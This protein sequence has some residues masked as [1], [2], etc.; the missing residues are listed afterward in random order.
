MSGVV[1]HGQT[2]GLP[3]RQ[4]RCLAD[5]NGAERTA[6]WGYRAIEAR[7]ISKSFRSGK[8]SVEALHDI[9]IAVGRGEVVS[10][11]GPSGSG[12]STLLHVLAGL[13]SPERG[14]VVID[15][16]RVENPIGRTALMPQRDL[17]MPWKTVLENVTVGMR[18]RGV[19]RHDAREEALRLFPRFGLEGFESA[20]PKALSGGMRQR[21]AL[22]RTL[23]TGR[24]IL[25]L[26]EPLGALDAITRMEMQAWLLEVQAS[27]QTTMLLVTHDVDEALYLSDR[28]AVLSGRPGRVVTT[29]AVPFSRPRSYE[30]TVTSSGFA[31][32]KR[33][34]LHQLREGLDE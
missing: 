4:R 7:H 34:I 11:L 6:D 13:I 10:I 9:S 24:D 22:L 21:A 18:L 15:G 29:H 1:K 26:D 16:E 30:E 12:K 32:L 27:F 31:H 17:L 20:Y 23:L 3:L 2:Q 19:S 5:S 28:V 14:E 8:Q 25:L 33:E